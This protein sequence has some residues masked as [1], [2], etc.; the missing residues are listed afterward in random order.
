MEKAE[1]V[2]WGGGIPKDSVKINIHGREK[3]IDRDI[4]KESELGYRCVV[5]GRKGMNPLKDLVLGSVPAKLIE[6]LSSIPLVVVGKNPR[7]GSAL[8]A[9]DGSENS[10]GIVD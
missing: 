4:L 2:L 7:P 6:K 1:K 3:G 8:L 5:V 9:L 10:R